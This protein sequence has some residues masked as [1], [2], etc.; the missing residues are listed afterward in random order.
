MAAF[1]K[2]LKLGILSKMDQSKTKQ[3]YDENL[4]GL[5]LVC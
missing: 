3:N 4:V 1:E 2:D 5:F